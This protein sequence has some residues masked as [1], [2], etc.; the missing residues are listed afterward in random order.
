[1]FSNDSLLLALTAYTA[2]QNCKKLVDFI[3]L[4]QNTECTL[5]N[6]NAK[7][8]SRQPLYSILFAPGFSLISKMSQMKH[9]GQRKY[10]VNGSTQPQ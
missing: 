2:T 5:L 3:R 8:H 10:T 4:K 6:T 9:I 1:M 7:N